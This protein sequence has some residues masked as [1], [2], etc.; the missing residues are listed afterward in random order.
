VT[1]T[2]GLS[3]NV[4]ESSQDSTFRVA[5]IQTCIC[6]CFRSYFLGTGALF[7]FDWPMFSLT[8]RESFH[9][10]VR[11]PSRNGSHIPSKPTDKSLALCRLDGRP[12]MFNLILWLIRVRSIGEGD[13]RDQVDTK[14]CSQQVSEAPTYRNRMVRY[15]L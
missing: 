2:S 9:R 11:E 3:R 14:G 13:I 8:P 6:A 10:D 5:V 7:N 4:I 12:R 1:V 15:Q